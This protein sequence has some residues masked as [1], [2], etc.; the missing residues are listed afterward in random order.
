[1]E[2]PDG[3]M[4]NFPH[5]LKTAN[6]SLITNVTTDEAQHSI[7][8]KIPQH[9]RKIT[10]YT[11]K[12]NKEKPE[13]KEKEEEDLPKNVP[14]RRSNQSLASPSASPTFDD[15]RHKLEK[16]AKIHGRYRLSTSLIT[17][18][19]GTLTQFCLYIQR[20]VAVAK[21]FPEHGNCKYIEYNK[22]ILKIYIAELR[23]STLVGLSY[24]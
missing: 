2:C 10:Q 3:A 21:Q 23:N 19:S 7:Y 18:Q 5:A 24:L 4:P 20:R 9:K 22:L 12:E 14:L 13:E 17:A 1:M 11:Q 8:L 16:Y 6:Q 15:G